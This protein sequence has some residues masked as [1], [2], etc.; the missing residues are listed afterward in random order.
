MTDNSQHA[1]S[2]DRLHVVHFMRPIGPETLVLLQNCVLGAV[3]QKATRVSL[4]ISS[5][6]GNNDQGFTA[7]H[8]LRSL[9]V[10]VETHCI[11]NVESMAVLLFLAGEDRRI[12]PH[13]KLKVHPMLWGFAAGTVDH[14]RLVEYADSL[15][16]DAKRY[17]NIF[18]ERTGTGTRRVDVRS[19]L[20]GKAEFLD[21]KQA[22]DA[23]IATAV[24]DATIPDS[25]VIWWV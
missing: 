24:A 3:Q 18:D 13:G 16:F 9:P 2:P 23:G 7:Y 5:A 17:A 1:G 10:A 21:A 12:V 8:F 4:H 14:D 19:H 25:A 22:V 20:A 6:G 15:N 11:G